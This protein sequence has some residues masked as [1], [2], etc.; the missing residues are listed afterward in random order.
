MPPMSDRCPL[1]EGRP[2][3]CGRGWVPGCIRLLTVACLVLTASAGSAD[4]QVTYTGRSPL[5]SF[6]FTLSN[7][8]LSVI[9]VTLTNQLCAG[10]P[11]S[12]VVSFPL[13]QV[14]VRSGSDGRQHFAVQSVP[15]PDSRTVDIVGILFDGDATYNTAEQGVGGLSL[16]V[17]SGHC[18]T[19]WAATTLWDIDG[20]GWSNS[21]EIRLGSDYADAARTPEHRSLPA[22]PGY[23]AAPCTDTVD[24]DLDGV[25]DAAD[26]DCVNRSAKELIYSRAP[27]GTWILRVGA[28]WTPLHPYTTEEMASA[29]FDGNVV[30]DLI[31]DFGDSLGVWL[32]MNNT[33]WVQL[34]TMSPSLMAVDDLDGNGRDDIVLDFTG[35]GVFVRYDDGAWARLLGRD[36]TRIVTGN[37]D[38]A[39]GA[40]VI[41]DVP[42]QGIWVYRNNSSWSPLHYLNSSGIVTGNLDGV[43]GDEVVIN[44]PGAGVWQYANDSTWSLLNQFNAS[45]MAVGNVDGVPA[46]DLVIDFGLSRGTWMLR[47]GTSWTGISTSG[48]VQDVLMAD[49]DGDGRDDIVFNYGDSHAGLTGVWVWLNDAMWIQLH[50]LGP[51]RLAVG[52]LY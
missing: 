13:G 7:D 8:G 25:S 51:D 39:G 2:R 48:D 1:F 4:A 36:A 45:H 23:L 24:N 49:L 27:F 46:E 20:D 29:N 34:H 22:V 10:A 11:N 44:F 28:G 43:A 35:Y 37:I 12:F 15:L 52:D 31:I 30:D 33:T 3:D 32:W 21:A 50:A 26:P 16:S 38:N 6:S 17:P 9:E 47:N 42:S 19:S 41:V 5:G 18:A 40:E 14:P